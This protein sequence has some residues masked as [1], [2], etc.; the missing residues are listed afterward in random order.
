MREDFITYDFK[1][2][3]KKLKEKYQNVYKIGRVLQEK[4]GITIFQMNMF[5]HRGRWP[6]GLKESIEKD[7]KKK[8]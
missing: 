2:L 1:S 8:I 5:C 3:Y 6:I 4:F 7:L